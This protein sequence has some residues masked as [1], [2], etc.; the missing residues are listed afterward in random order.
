MKKILSFQIKNLKTLS[1]ISDKNKFGDKKLQGEVN[2]EEKPD[3]NFNIIQKTGKQNR[4]S[5]DP[6]LFQG[7]ETVI[8]PVIVGENIPLSR[9]SV[10]PPEMEVHDFSYFYEYKISLFESRN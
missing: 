1:A 7:Q 10:D 6:T 9:Y 8:T 5:K 4:F 3:L 2:N